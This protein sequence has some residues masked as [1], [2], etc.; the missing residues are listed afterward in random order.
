MDAG[1]RMTGNPARILVADT[2]AGYRGISPVC[3]RI[4]VVGAWDDDVPVSVRVQIELDDDERAAE[5]IFTLA[6][7]VWQTQLLEVKAPDREG[8]V[9]FFLEKGGDGALVLYSI[10]VDGE[11]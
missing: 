3:Y 10:E 5:R 2:H 11:F 6:K 1:L 4:R 7:G 8:E 9:R